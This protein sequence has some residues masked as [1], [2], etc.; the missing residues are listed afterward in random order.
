VILL[1]FSMPLL[2][3]KNIMTAQISKNRV[4]KIRGGHTEDMTFPKILDTSS[5]EELVNPDVQA[6]SKYS[7]DQPPTTL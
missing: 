5:I 3:P 6:F 2:T 1:N 7:N 4:W